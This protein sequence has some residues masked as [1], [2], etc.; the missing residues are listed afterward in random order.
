M[1]IHLLGAV[2]SFAVLFLISTAGAQAGTVTCPS[3]VA[4]SGV[5]L[6]DPPGVGKATENTGSQLICSFPVFYTAVAQEVSQG[7]CTTATKS[8]DFATSGG[9]GAWNIG[10][11][12]TANPVILHAHYFQAPTLP[13][14]GGGTIPGIHY[15]Y[16]GYPTTQFTITPTFTLT[17][18]T[19]APAGNNCV[20]ASANS[21]TC[22]PPPPTP[23]PATIVGS[24]IPTASFPNP[25][26]STNLP[27][28]GSAWFYA[29]WSGIEQLAGTSANGALFEPQNV[30][31]STIQS[32][33]AQQSMPP[34]ATA[35]FTS[36]YPNG[37]PYSVPPGYIDCIYAGPSFPF[38]FSESNYILAATVDIVCKGTACT[39]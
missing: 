23:C 20:I 9:T 36:A 24:Q 3:L 34:L 13:R 14:P 27:T 38:V 26:S 39:L 11:P 2:L 29:R 10:P 35:T 4:P 31:L 15:C 12:G 6:T 17:A 7:V 16:Y 19:A 22:T 32:A 21:F 28:T 33:M 1:K 5:T 25:W 18:S 37:A 8:L 30:S